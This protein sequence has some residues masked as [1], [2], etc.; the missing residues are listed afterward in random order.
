VPGILLATQ[1]GYALDQSF[2]PEL[3]V[4]ATIISGIA[5]IMLV[6]RYRRYQREQPA[7]PAN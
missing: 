4:I 1:F 6:Y 5:T 3:V 2:S 7:N